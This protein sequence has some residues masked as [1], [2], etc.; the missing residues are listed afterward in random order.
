MNISF[1]NFSCLHPKSH[2]KLTLCKKRLYKIPKFA[3]PTFTQWILAAFPTTFLV[4]HTGNIDVVGWQD[5]TTTSETQR[6]NNW[7][8]FDRQA[9]NLKSY[10]KEIVKEKEL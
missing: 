6:F 9:R 4:H 8:L 3:H 7:G 2:V 1:H 5:T 10:C